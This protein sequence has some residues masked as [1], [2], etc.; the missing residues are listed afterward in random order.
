MFYLVAVNPSFVFLQAVFYSTS[1]QPVIAPRHTNFLFIMN[2]TGIVKFFNEEKGYGFIK[3]DKDG[4]DYF[5][6]AKGLIDQVKQ[7]DKV[8]YV[9]K[10]GKK[11]LNAVSVKLA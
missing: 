6:H 10:E 9:L 11:G 3:D 5:V 7:N 2:N 1:K 8:T 4:K